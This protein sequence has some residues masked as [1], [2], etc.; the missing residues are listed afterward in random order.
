MTADMNVRQ[1]V[2]SYANVDRQNDVRGERL[3]KENRWVMKSLDRL[4]KKEGRRLTWGMT[5]FRT[6]N[7]GKVEVATG[8]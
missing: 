5:T 3:H 8:E 4:E 2:L 6:R 1:F 7:L